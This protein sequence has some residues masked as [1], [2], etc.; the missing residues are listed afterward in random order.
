MIY[1]FLV[2]LFL[3]IL[4]TI[5]TRR[6]TGGIRRGILDKWTEDNR[7]SSKSCFVLYRL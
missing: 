3:F 4:F 2:F 5:I 6:F 7:Y 1:L